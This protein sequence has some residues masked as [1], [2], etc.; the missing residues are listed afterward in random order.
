MKYI[1]LTLI[2]LFLTTQ[3]AMAQGGGPSAEQINKMFNQGKSVVELIDKTSNERHK[4][5]CLTNN[6]K[7]QVKKKIC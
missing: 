3:L 7:N 2:A 6:G 4:Q 1:L 5:I